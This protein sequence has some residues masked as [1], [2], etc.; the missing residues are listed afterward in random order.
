MGVTL[1][2][3]HELLEQDH[4]DHDVGVGA[5][6]DL[7]AVHCEPRRRGL[8]ITQGAAQASEA[9]AQV[10]ERLPVPAI[11]GEQTGQRVPALGRALMGGQVGEQRA[12]GVG[13]EF[14]R[15]SPHPH[16]ERPQHLYP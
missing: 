6:T 8:V 3:P 2:R 10:G 1:H 4:V 15:T 9:V 12:L 14:D 11:G 13:A 5:Q 16:L 7:F